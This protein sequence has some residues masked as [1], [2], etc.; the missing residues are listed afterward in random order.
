MAVQYQWWGPTVGALAKAATSGATMVTWW[1]SGSFLKL[2]RPRILFIQHLDGVTAESECV[3]FVHKGWHLVGWKLLVALLLLGDSPAVFRNLFCA[4][5]YK[6]TF[7]LK[8]LCF[9]YLYC[10]ISG[11]KSDD[12]TYITLFVLL[13]HIACLLFWSCVKFGVSKTIFVATVDQLVTRGWESIIRP[14]ALT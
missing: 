5:L 7:L 6:L 14:N 11:R 13:K 8:S 2:C 1:H 9:G 12:Q 3:V 4:F 10:Q